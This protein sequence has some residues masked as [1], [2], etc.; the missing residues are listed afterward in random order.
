MKNLTLCMLWV[1]LLA[2]SCDDSQNER[3]RMPSQEQLIEAN[4]KKV[5]TESRL[6]DDFVDKSGWKMNVTETGIRYEVYFDSAGTTAKSRDQVAIHYDLY[7]L[8]GTRVGD[9]K[10][11]GPVQFKVGEG[12]VVSGLHEAVTYLSEG[13]SARIILPSYLA[14]GL[15]GD[16]N[17]IPPNAALFY[18]LS[19]VYI[20]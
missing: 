1:L 9:T 10:L 4:K 20:N 13:D 11:K 5:G 16:Q 14:F 7:L 18:N 15:T 19:L 6:I 8:D 2:A 17:N 3:G 12:D